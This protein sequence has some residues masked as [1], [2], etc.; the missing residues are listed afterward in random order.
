MA[1]ENFIL[2]VLK[3]NATLVLLFPQVKQYTEIHPKA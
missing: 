3:W 2:K 1:M